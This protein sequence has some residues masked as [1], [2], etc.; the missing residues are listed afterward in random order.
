MDRTIE[1]KAYING[2]FE[3]CCIGI[4]QGKISKIKKI[5]KSDEHIDFGNKIILP[6]G[7]DIHV[8]FRDPGFTKKE[9]FKTGSM[10]AA[11]GGI[12]C[13]FDMPN[14]HPPTTTLNT[15]NE[16]LHIADIKSYIDF[17][18][19]ASLTNDNIKNINILAKKCSGFKIYL[20]DTPNSLQ[21]NTQ[22]LE[23]A[24]QKINKT[25]SIVLIH[26]ENIQCLKKHSGIEHNLKDH[27]RHRP[28]ECEEIS[29]KNILD[30]CKDIPLK[31]HICHLSSCEGLLAL[32]NHTKNISIG[33]TPHH[34]F[35]DIGMIKSN[36]P[37]Y[38]V[39]PPIRSNLDRE[40]LWNAVTDGSIDVLES[41]HAPHTLEEKSRE[42]DKAP[43]GMPGVETMLPMFLAQVKNQKMSFNRLISLLCEKPAELLD[44]PKGRIEIGKDA[45][46]IVIDFKD[47]KIIKTDKLHSKYGWST[48]EGKTAIFPSHVF[49]RGEEIIQE[50]ELVGSQGIGRNVKSTFP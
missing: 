2:A 47:V 16:K 44:I 46:L 13:V 37:F 27:L 36:Q 24:F 11:Y 12:S 40:T 29:I 41:D 9:D 5:L 30:S 18:I 45:D 26:A 32:K 23:D 34:L 38:K 43:S 8:H 39:N 28:S 50:Y 25:N 6:S 3:K 33:V 4:K 15:I 7:I 1:G 35:F 49:M 20:G 17:G 42:F 22:F 10:A 48:F 19:Y 14:T 31:I 21:F